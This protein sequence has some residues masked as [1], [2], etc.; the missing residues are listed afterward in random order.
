MEPTL[1]RPKLAG[2]DGVRRAEKKC[3]CAPCL[4]G[5]PAADSTG[6]PLP[7]LRTHEMNV[8]GAVRERKKRSGAVMVDPLSGRIVP[9]PPQPRLVVGPDGKAA[10]AAHNPFRLC[11]HRWF[12]QP[13]G[14]PLLDGSLATSCKA[15]AAAGVPDPAVD[16]I[17]MPSSAALTDTYSGRF[18]SVYTTGHRQNTAT[19]RVVSAATP[20]VAYSSGEAGRGEILTPATAALLAY[21]DAYDGE[22]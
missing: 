2:N 14:V 3:G 18:S 11:P 7:T 15:M 5:H 16:A 20:H 17:Y 22:V 4:C 21:D 19:A 13:D 9:A 12:L 6:S 10:R 1:K 8:D